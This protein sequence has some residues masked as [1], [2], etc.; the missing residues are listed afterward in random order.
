MN[1]KKHASKGVR[2]GCDIGGTFTDIVLAM[3]NG[4]LYVNKTSTTPD[5][6]G[7]A[8][9]QGLGSLIEQAGVSPGDITEIVHGTTTAS[10]TILQKVGA[11]TGVL[12]TE[13]FRDVLEIGRIRTPTMF[14]LSWSKPAPLSPRRWRR[15]IRERIDA[16]GRIVTPLDEAQLLDEARALVDEGVGSMAVCFLN[17][18]I[19]P[20][21]ELAA[22]ALLQANF[23]SLLLSV[24]CEVLPEIKEY[25]RTSTTVVNA[26]ILPAMRTYL[27]RLRQDLERMGVKA[28]LQVMA[29]NG[30]MMGIASATDKP[31]FAVASGPAGGVA[32]AV[33]IGHLG[34]DADLIVFDMGGTTAKASIIAGGQPSLT[35][36]YEFR[37][38][39]SAPSRFVKGG[40]Y[41]LKVPAIDIA[42]V[43]A[44]GG[45]IAWIDA[46]GLLCVGPESAGATPGP[47]CYGNGNDRPTVTD[48]NMVLGYLNPRALAGGSLRVSPELSKAAIE[49]HVGGPLGLDLLAAAH[50]IRQVANVNMARAIRAVTV[51]RGRDPRD[52]SIIAFGGGGPLHAVSVARLLGIRRVIAPIMAGVF[53]SA[54]MLSADAE[55]NFVKAVL[56]PLAG[57]APAELGGIAAALGDKGYSVLASEGYQPED[58]TIVLAADLRYVGQ[59]SELTV[60]LA[61]A[62]FGLEAIEQL[63]RDFQAMYHQT[64][65]YS[66]DEPLELVNLR[67]SARGRSKHRL[68][69]ATC[70][71]DGTALQGEAGTRSVSFAA[72][73]APVA[74]RVVPR[75]QLTQAPEQGPLVIESYDTTIV[76]PP[77]CSAHADAV[78]NIIIDLQEQAA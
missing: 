31:V 62:H 38:G 8:I 54:G 43:G 46:G 76:V 14:D 67:V 29:S 71:V 20:V 60:A 2:V 26:Y 32:G 72:N 25:E 50:G 45:S 21:H 40:G 19:N 11:R 42:E 70:Q 36:E 24:S 59:S 44:G 58:A 7:R 75:A 27:A 68:D 63:V 61:S 56:K 57:C 1:L 35:N 77:H 4:R 5:D 12:T 37:D 41:V 28:S 49:R 47:A 17:S 53:C 74:T 51:E 6:L 15:G 66:S 22:K 55:H 18:Y 30:G 73:E 13:G 33:E 3:P 23:P 52:M 16:Q 34:G 10:N 78:G 48:A 69:F 39:I 9:V 65:G 64:F